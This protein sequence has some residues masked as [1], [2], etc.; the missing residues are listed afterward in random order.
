MVTKRFSIKEGTIAIGGGGWFLVDILDTTQPLV[1]AVFGV[2]GVPGWRVKSK[3]KL[4]GVRPSL[5]CWRHR[6]HE[7][8][9]EGITTSFCRHMNA[10]RWQKTRN[11]GQ[12]TRLW[13]PPLSW[14]LL[15]VPV[16]TGRWAGSKTPIL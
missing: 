8:V 10:K 16:Y 15:T 7:E 6:C 13:K 9:R 3:C 5:T 1:C 4:G 12:Q 2:G 14:F 11:P